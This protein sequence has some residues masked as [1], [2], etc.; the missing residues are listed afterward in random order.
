MGI[1]LG[2]LFGFKRDDRKSLKIYQNAE[3]YGELDKS[4]KFIDKINEWRR[5][6]E[7]YV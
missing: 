5:N 7:L 1:A 2:L 3:K 4:N 6:E